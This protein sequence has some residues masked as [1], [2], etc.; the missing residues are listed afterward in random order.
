M[1]TEAMDSLSVK[2]R[3]FLLSAGIRPDPELSE[4]DAIVSHFRDTYGVE[5]MAF[6]EQEWVNEQVDRDFGKDGPFRPLLD[7]VFRQNAGMSALDD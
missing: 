1:R 3:S 4:S 2:I 6:L 5:M 7:K